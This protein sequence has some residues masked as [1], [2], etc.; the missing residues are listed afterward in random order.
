MKKFEYKVVAMD[1]SI[2]TGRAKADYLQILNEYGAQGWRFTGFTPGQARPAKS[3][4]VEM[5]FER[6]SSET[7]G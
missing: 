2:W 1:F 3:K 7:A 4:G 6:E 5:I